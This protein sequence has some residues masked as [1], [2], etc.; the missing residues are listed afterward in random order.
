MLGSMSTRRD[1]Y[2]RKPK[3]SL[4]ISEGDV[5]ILL[6]LYRFR[7]L[8]TE[9]LIRATGRGPRVLRER[10]R[11]LFDH[12]YIDRPN[13][14]RERNLWRSG[15]SSLVYGLRREGARVLEEMGAVPVEGLNWRWKNQKVKR[16]FLLHTLDLAEVVLQLEAEVSVSPSLSS[17]LVDQFSSG[18]AEGPSWAVSVSGYGGPRR[19]LTI[20]PDA[21]A[22]LDETKNSSLYFIELDRGTMPVTSSNPDRSSVR[23]KLIAYHESW[24]QNAHHDR[25]GQV[26]ARVLFV[27]PS[28]SRIENMREAA[29]RVFD[30]QG[31]PRRRGGHILFSTL[32]NVK[33]DGVLGA[34]WLTVQGANK[35]LY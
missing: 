13:A 25:F 16:P 22:R 17:T 12:G 7:F 5:A 6:L 14:Q 34:D 30:E 3:A 11:R 31:S 19:E 15:S 28:A 9:Q 20:V 35:R 23:R 2:V 27:A 26:G 18:S 8:S 1:Y 32:D 24:K 21:V 4:A 29:S 33:S 10:L